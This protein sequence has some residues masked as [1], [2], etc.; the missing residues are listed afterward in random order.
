MKLR[1]NKMH[2]T[3]YIED[4]ILTLNHK[5]FYRFLQELHLTLNGVTVTNFF[6]ISFS[7][8][9]RTEATRELSMRRVAASSGKGGVMRRWRDGGRGHGGKA[10]FLI[11][12]GQVLVL[13]RPSRPQL[14]F[15]VGGMITHRR[16]G[17]L[18]R[19]QK[20]RE[21]PSG[22]TWRASWSACSEP[23]LGR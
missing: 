2:R 6:L 8:R 18:S 20:P 11:D 19:L 15:F 21:E 4:K 3:K 10:G 14:D 1:K 17:F 9:E 12:R 5:H 7:L 13:V 23:R 16:L 22:Q